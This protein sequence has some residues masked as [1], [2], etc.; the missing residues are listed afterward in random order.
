MYFLR[1]FFIEFPSRVSRIV[2]KI[3]RFRIYESVRF[4]S[5]SLIFGVLVMVQ[6]ESR[7]LWYRFRVN[8]LDLGLGLG[9]VF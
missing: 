5:Y 6:G 2:I 9:F 8:S 3:V 7:G 1:L 4:W